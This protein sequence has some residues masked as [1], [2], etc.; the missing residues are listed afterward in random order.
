MTSD[1]NLGGP[2]AMIDHRAC[3]YRSFAGSHERFT[4]KYSMLAI[5]LTTIA[6][7]EIAE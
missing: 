4:M 6:L 7:R 1:G 2:L 5:L 3:D